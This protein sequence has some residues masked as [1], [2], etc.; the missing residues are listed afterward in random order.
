VKRPDTNAALRALGALVT[1]VR[2]TADLAAAGGSKRPL[3]AAAADTSTWALALLRGGAALRALV[4]S[5][6][7]L[8]QALRVGFHIDVW[9]DDIGPGL[10]LPHPFGIVVGDGVRIEEG[11]TLMHGVTIQRGRGTVV[12]RGAVL[13]NGVTVLAGSRVGAGALVGAASVVRGEVPVG[14]VAVG[15]PAR[16]TR[17]RFEE[18]AA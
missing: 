9:T 16:V 6:C 17:A 13:A 3:L 2:R 12:G 10:R 4:G 18:Q 15:A 14:T 11:C 7:G 8:H 1:D 5:S